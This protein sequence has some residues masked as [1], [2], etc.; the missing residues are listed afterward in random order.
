MMSILNHN[1]E[2]V[3]EEE[4]YFNF[5][6]SIKS[7]VTKKVY[8][9]NIKSF[10]KFCN[11]T[12]LSDLLAIEPQKQIIKYLMSLRERRLAF[13]S[14]SI[15]LK[16]IYHF[17]EMNDV[18]L[19]KKKIN[20]FKGE[21]SRRVVD[22]AYT[23]EEIKKILD[24]SD[25]RMKS[26]ILLMASSGIRIGAIPLLRLINIEKIDSIYK[27]T[28]YEGS[29]AE[30]YTFCTPECR[31]FIDAYIEYR[32]Q[33]G[34][35][36]HNDSF[37]IR[38]QFD[39]SDIEQVRNKSRGITVNT[40]KVL[41]DTVLVKSGVRTVDHT[42]Y[43]RKEVAKSHGF[44]KF[45]TTQAVNSKVSPELREMLLGHKIGLASCYYRPTQHE[46]YQEYH[47]AI[48]NLTINEENR[49]RNKVKILEIE[50][51]RL[52]QLELALKR[53]EGIYRKG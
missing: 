15:K 4:V 18:I 14:L 3:K 25:L 52:D 17:Y 43:V 37:L 28:V 48:D 23:H 50:K 40:I 35:K 21:F 9:Y 13:N 51:S 26:I 34:E 24:V 31:S 41:V 11:V 49:L 27:I 7:E 30:Y 47:K 36:L 20:M 2:T 10:M 1:K 19:N 38:D 33:N 5:I 39:I 44:R 32:T 45:F 46:V 29:N 16:T 12:K 42:K 8:E 6:N 22:R 53:L